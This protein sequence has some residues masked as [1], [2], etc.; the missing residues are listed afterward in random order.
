ML[1][2][3][4]LNSCNNITYND[5]TILKKV[6]NLQDNEY[7]DNILINSDFR[8]YTGGDTIY[9]MPYPINQMGQTTYTSILHQ[10]LHELS[11]D[12]WYVFNGAT[13]S[14]HDNYLQFRL[15]DITSEVGQITS[16]ELV[17]LSDSQSIM[18]HPIL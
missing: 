11:I 8:K 4:E 12:C 10:G 6:S 13:L 2:V 7:H 5:S 14:L 16:Y 9:R 1:Y 3:K 18:R 17:S 15:P